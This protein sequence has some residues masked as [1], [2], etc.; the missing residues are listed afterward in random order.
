MDAETAAPALAAAHLQDSP[1]RPQ[2]SK[3]YYKKRA[4]S[5]SGNGKDDAANHDESKNQPPG[6]PLS[7]QS[8]SSSA[9][10][11][12]HT[13]GFYEI[14]H[15][16]LPPKSPIHLKSIR[17]VKVSGY[18]S[19]DVTVSFPSL[20]ALRSFFSSSP[21]PRTGPELDER[22][23]MSSN[24]A[25]RILRRRVAEEELAGEAMHQDSF[26]LVKPCLYDFSASS[27]PAS[28]H[29]ALT[30][31]PPAAARA[32]APAASSCLLDTLKCDGTG[33]GV[34]RRVRYIGRH[35]DASKEASAASLDGYDTEVSV[36]DEQQRRL[37]LRQRQAQEDNKST[38]NGKRKR[39][40]AESS[41]DKRRDERKK[42][43][44][45]YKSP[46]KAEKKRVVEAKD[47][48][49]RRG[50]DRWSA[51]R[52]A[53][54]ERSLLDIMRSRGARFGAP[55]MRQA[56]REEARKHIGD[57]GLLDHLLKHMA[58]RVPEGS[59]DRFRRRHNADGA[60]EY[61][62]EPAELAEVRRQAG[63]SDPYWVPPPG[64]KPGDDVSSVA[65]DLLVKKKVEE[66]AE[67]VDGVKRHIEQLSSNLV[68]LD[69]ETKSE[70]E[71][72]Y[73]SRR[74]KYQKLVKANEKL[75]KQ[76]LSM[77][78]MYEHLVLK[79]GKLKKEVLSLKDKY[80]LVAEKNDK[81]EEQMASLSSS[82]LSLKEQLL[83]TKNG[84]NL[85]M[86]RERVEVT[87]GKQ[88]AVVPGKPLYVDGGDQISQQ[89]D[90]TVVQVGEKRTARK[91]S[92]RICKPQGTFMWP[93]MASGTS[94]AISGGGSSS[95]PI[96]TGPEQ[97]PRSSSCPSIGPGGLPPSS[98]APA[99]VVVA[100]P[101]DEHA[102]FRGGFNTPP[103]ASSTNAAA[104]AKLPPLPSPTS[105]LQTRALFAAGFTVP[106]LHNYSGLTLRHVDSSSPSSAPCG[107][108]EKMALFDGDGRGITTVGTELALATPSYC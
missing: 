34:R 44:K 38:S 84:D 69:K 71:R 13:G 82:F 62:L 74:E 67:E 26:W 45:T 1:M 70:A 76:V 103:S 47:G 100:S 89:A 51:E 18:T 101:L 8:L 48:D 54:A 3:Y 36:Q 57:T 85:N 107:A 73:S 99:E 14:D 104:A 81:L 80:K 68:Q 4:I 79:K 60:M 106:A 98:R 42:K 22:F 63:V 93:H 17:V 35:N 10:H 31:S 95:G 9:T 55:V 12:Y 20:L 77:K 27:H 24:Y 64:W 49:P 30:P 58:G 59:A 90:A 105:P 25:A 15:E 53:A 97:L 21:W 29:D 23:V 102:V 78:D 6:S 43:A 16:K 19:L 72:S 87:V 52:Y 83:L 50:K 39:E 75:E 91:S 32:K 2:V 28:P 46:K 66:L 33:W 86:E 41:Q 88:E 61:W 108:R 56:L 40:E 7:R 92:F 96:A 65:G 37:R 11:T 5:N 94:M